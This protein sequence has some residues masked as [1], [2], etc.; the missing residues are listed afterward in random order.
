MAKSTG[1]DALAKVEPD[2]YFRLYQA[3]KVMEVL[4]SQNQDNSEFYVGR[5]IDKRSN[6]F[7]NVNHDDVQNPPTFKQHQDHY[8]LHT[9]GHAHVM[10]MT[11]VEKLK[12]VC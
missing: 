10:S 9:S 4:K 12:T 3:L 11:L 8:P 1:C 7:V 6:I 2:A 5:M